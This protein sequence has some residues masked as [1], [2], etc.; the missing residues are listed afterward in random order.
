MAKEL[1]KKTF[2]REVEVGKSS[3]G[4]TYFYITAKDGKKVFINLIKD[5]KKFVPNFKDNTVALEISFTSYNKDFENN[6]RQITYF[7]VEVLS[8]IRGR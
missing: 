1:E 7:N 4:N 3:K 6:N 2:S 5:N 8:E